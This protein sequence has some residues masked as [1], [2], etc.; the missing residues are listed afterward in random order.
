MMILDMLRERV[1]EHTFFGE[2]QVEKPVVTE[3]K[4][5]VCPACH[6]EHPY[7]D[8]MARGKVCPTC[9]K[10]LRMT[11]RERISQIFDPDSFQEIAKD[12]TSVD[13]LQFPGYAE[14]LEKTKESTGEQEAVLCGTASIG[15][16]MCATFVMDSSFFMASMGSVVGE[17]ITRLFEL[18]LEQRLP[19]I[20]FTASGGARR[21]E[22]VA[23]QRSGPAVHS[24]ADRPDHR[25][26]DGVLCDA[27]GHYS[28]RAEGAGGLRGQTCRRADDRLSAS[29][30]FP[31]RGIF[32]G[33]RLCG[34]RG[35]SPPASGNAREAPAAARR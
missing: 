21:Q 7:A 27:G 18:A 2:K 1:Q 22:G 9:G 6:T 34:C 13:F 33:P 30:Q 35:G 4:P 31:A 8:L 25:R 10:Y 19:V 15:G 17:K 11:A 3:K 23:P 5:V 20:G 14:K 16:V 29:V 24:G 26:R 12:L 32:A 28:G